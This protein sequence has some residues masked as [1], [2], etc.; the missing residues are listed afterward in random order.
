MF[1]DS[2]GKKNRSARVAHAPAHA[3]ADGQSDD[4][5]ARERADGEVGQ[6]R[7]EEGRGRGHAHEL[8][9][10]AGVEAE[11]YGQGDAQDRA[12]AQR[13]LDE[14]RGASAVAAAEGVAHLVFEFMKTSLKMIY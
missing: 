10:A 13:G 8:E 5:G 2:R 11:A 7:R 9:E 6:R 12:D 4:G 1:E 14:L 3:F